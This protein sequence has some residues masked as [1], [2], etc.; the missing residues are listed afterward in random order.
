MLFRSGGG[1]G[2]QAGTQETFYNSAP[3][4]SPEPGGVG[5]Q[6]GETIRNI[7]SGSYT[8]PAGFLAEQLNEQG[9][10]REPLPPV[11]EAS[12]RPLPN[13]TPAPGAAAQI[14]AVG[15][16]PS[17]T[18]PGA[19]AGGG[20]PED[21]RTYLERLQA[22]LG[23]QLED[24]AT[25]ARLGIGLGVGGIGA[26]QQM[27]SAAAAKQARKDQAALGEPY[28]QQGMELIDQARRGELSPAS[29]Q[30]YQAAQAK[31]AQQQARTGG[32]GVMQGA[33]NL[34]RLRAQLLQNQY[35][36]GLN[37]ANIGN[38]YIRGA[39]QTGLQANQ[40]LQQATTQFFTGLTSMLGGPTGQA[41]ASAAR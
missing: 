24:P 19:G 35:Q 32:V 5:G 4:P 17:G 39:I 12:V 8:P 28:R 31:I 7:A 23:K 9:I 6:A 41:I 1:E 10:G 14:S 21:T 37:V 13:V 30:A 20:K 26:L 33:A 16:A 29:A 36:L 15:G 22:N 11:T 27:R 40:Q 2:F 25:L 34:E 18:E 3:E 38:Q